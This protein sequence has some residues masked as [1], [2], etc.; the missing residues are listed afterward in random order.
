M[1]PTIRAL[2]FFEYPTNV[3]LGSIETF[4]NEEDISFDL[5]DLSSSSNR[6]K[7][8][9][10]DALVIL[11]GRMGAYETELHPQLLTAID[12]IE[13]AFEKEIPVLGIC[14][15]A[16]LMAKT[17]G[18]D[19]H[20]HTFPEIG[21][22]EIEFTDEALADPLLNFSKRNMLFS[23]WHG[24]TFQIPKGATLL[25]KSQ[26]CPRQGFRYGKKAYGFQF[27][28]EANEQKID[29]WRS[30][31]PHDSRINPKLADQLPQEWALYGETQTQWM[32]QFMH[33]FL[34]LI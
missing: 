13:D 20:P 16:Q 14:L 15:G 27:H 23:E 26:I 19:V 30:H 24:D 31:I 33:G 9:N 10:S 28:P 18:A 21:W 34:Q 4:L 12:W 6:P 29:F 17:L 25:A 22:T 2:R 32:R 1:L 7:P 5:I 11:G 8:E 3:A